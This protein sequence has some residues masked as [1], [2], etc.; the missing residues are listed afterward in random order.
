[1]QVSCIVSSPMDAVSRQGTVWFFLKKN[2][3]KI[4]HCIKRH[5]FRLQMDVCFRSVYMKL[6]DTHLRDGI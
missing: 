1:M 2:K 5:L 4:N 3:I 6:S